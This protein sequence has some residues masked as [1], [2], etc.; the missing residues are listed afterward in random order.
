M[1]RPVEHSKFYS[2]VPINDDLSYGVIVSGL[3]SGDLQNEALQADLRRLWAQEGVLVFDGIEGERVQ[4]ELSNIF[5]QCIIHP[6]KEQNTGA[7]EGLVNILYRP[8]DGWLMEV[9]G[10]LRGQWLPWHSDLIYVD[11]IN[12]GGLLR[13][14]QLPSRLGETG[15]ID[16][17]E[18]YD[19]LPEA[20]KQKIEGLHVIYA[21]DV[22]VANQR[23]GRQGDARV[24]RYSEPLRKVKERESEF[25]TVAHPMVF[26]QAETGRKVLNVSPWFAVGIVEMPGPDGEQL[27]SDVIEHIVRNGKPYYHRWEMGQ[28]VLWDNWRM[29]HCANG[30]PADETRF[31]QRTTIVGDYGLGRIYEGDNKPSLEYISV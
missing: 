27:L 11:K 12:H 23:F 26:T 17:I 6:V 28:M 9:D 20:L 21:Y 22:D 1:S 19:S 5:G 14:I 8:E 16:K 2:A 10:E 31:L 15:F 25:A 18:T 24:V 3:N 4:L 7:P 13:P 30:S 29:L